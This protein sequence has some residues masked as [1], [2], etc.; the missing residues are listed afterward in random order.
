MSEVNNEIGKRIRT[1]RKSRG[2]TQNELA[3][4]YT[5]VS[6]IPIS[7]NMI[8]MWESGD[9]RIYADQ[10]YYLCTIFERNP[11]VLYPHPN[12]NGKLLADEVEA[13]M[14]QDFNILRY[15]IT[16]WNGNVKALFQFIALYV[17]LPK[18]LRQDIAGMGVSM[19]ELG[20]KD[21]KLLDDAPNV[22]LEYLKEETERLWKYNH[23]EF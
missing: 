12:V 1:I 18:Q 9:R 4:K 21:D 22:D 5:E 3:N 2:L 7:A 20:I 13:F 17:S 23:N 16:K 6:E 19:Y 11:T 10:L 8:S 14:S 15:V